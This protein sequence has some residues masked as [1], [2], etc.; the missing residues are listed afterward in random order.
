MKQRK[1]LRVRP[2]T[3]ASL[4]KRFMGIEDIANLVVIE[5]P[6]IRRSYKNT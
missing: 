5:A 2:A 4:S 1:G 3:A 6:K